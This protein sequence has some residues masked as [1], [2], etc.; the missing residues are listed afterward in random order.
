MKHLFDELSF[1]VS[2][3]TTKKY[4]TSFSLGILALNE[5]IRP[6]IYAIYGYVRLAD[7]IVDSFHDYD[8]EQL[9]KRF[10]LQTKEALEER[11]SLNP[12][13]N[14]F[15]H[16]VHEYQIDHE[17]IDTFLR[18][19]EM[20]LQTIDYN[21]ELYDT[22]ILGSAEVVGLMCLQVFVKGDKSEYER[23]K[24]YAMRLG[25]AFQKV[26]FLRDL[27]DD[28]HILGRTYFPNVDLNA[29][30]CEVKTTIE[31]EIKSEFDVALTGIKMLPTSS[32]YGVYLAYR[33]YI[34]L[35][36]KI[37]CTSAEKIINQRIRINNGKKLSLMMSCYFQ[38]KLAML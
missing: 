32:K 33:Y 4:S 17:L 26:N 6:A 9:M 36:N 10:R 38:Y 31:A 24:P 5:E 27:K 25:S 28:F 2:K 23:L 14:T 12:I 35:F 1:R 34:S 7:E 18:S 19:M 30:T 29:F 11:I 3:E 21:S 15:Q 22:Y 20:D 37:K 13:L 8:K 16:V